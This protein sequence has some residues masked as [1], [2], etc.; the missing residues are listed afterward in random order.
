MKRKLQSQILLLT[1]VGILVYLPTFSNPFIWDDENII[2]KNPYLRKGSPLRE[3]F[4]RDL[5]YG[6]LPGSNFYRPL[7]TL[8]YRIDYFFWGT[9]PLGYHLSNFLLHL[10][11]SCL[12]LIILTELSRPRYS[13]VAA[14]FSL[15]NNIL[16]KGGDRL[17]TA[18]IY[19]FVKIREDSRLKSFP[20]EFLPFL[21]SVFFLVHPVHTEAVAYISGRADLLAATFIFLSLFFYLKG[22]K[23]TTNAHFKISQ[24]VSKSV[25]LLLQI[26]PIIVIARSG[27]TKQSHISRIISRLPRSLWSLAMTG[28]GLSDSLIMVRHSQSKED[29]RQRHSEFSP[30]GHSEPE[31][32]GGEE[33]HPK[34]H[35]EHIRF[36]QCKLREESL[37]YYFLSLLFYALALLSKEISLIF[38]FAL[39]LFPAIQDGRKKP[40]AKVPIA[41]FFLLTLG[42][43]LLRL[44]PLDFTSGSLLRASDSLPLRLLTFCKAIPVY[45]GLLLF[46]LNLHM[47]RTLGPIL[48]PGEVG[49]VFS[50]GVI[51]SFL[52][53]LLYFRKRLPLLWG[54]GLWFFLWL[55][56]VSNLVPL[57]ASLAEHWLYLPSLGFIVGAIFVVSA[58]PKKG[59]I[60]LFMVILLCFSILTW[61]RNG[62]WGDPL[63]FFQKNLRRS[64][65]SFMLP[66]ALGNI[67]KEKGMVNQAENKYLKAIELKP[68]F[69]E[70]HNNLALI[71][72]ERREISKALFEI[73]QALKYNP[74]YQDG[75]N[76]LGRIYEKMGELE[77]AKEAYQ[78]VLQLN[79]LLPEA[80]NNLGIVFYRRKDFPQAEKEFRQALKLRPSYPEAAYNLGNL[81]LQQGNLDRAIQYFQKALRIKPDYFFAR[82]NLG[83]AYAGKGDYISARREWEMVLQSDPD[84]E[85]ARENLKKLQQLGF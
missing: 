12:I 5:L 82:V 78:K 80:H 1:V 84:C 17:K 49:V 46:P 35:S 41:L 68:D 10:L 66:L 54:C 83:S 14:G 76:N 31:R 69:P 47:E 11:I 43:I 34:G 51:V 28:S 3:I 39:F 85:Q 56:P 15:R 48:N 70:A 71:Y 6:S 57:N 63:K 61:K 23:L 60:F 8:S 53:F 20:A 21:V 2:V 45:L 44:G 62:E 79:P 72:K 77:K 50:L 18:T 19:P 64:P 24:K 59:S 26:C 73:Q 22:E 81:F 4:S 65:H 33:S 74:V 40:S 9:N 38:P 25:A 67:Y 13:E 7:Q 29:L 75:L 27:A 30:A 16:S 58:V 42:Y 55:L 32:S 36:A 37:I 52:L